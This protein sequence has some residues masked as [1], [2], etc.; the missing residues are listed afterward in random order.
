MGAPMAARLAD[1]GFDVTVFDVRR[2]VS[3]AFADGHKVKCSPSI[4]DAV[5]NADALVAML[6]DD[7]AVR[8]VMLGAGAA[9]CCMAAGGIAIDMGTSSPKSTL[10][11]AGI[12]ALNAIAYVDAPVM[13]GVRFAQDG[14]LDVMV[15]GDADAVERCLPLFAALGRNTWRCGASGSGHALKAIANF[16]NAATLITLAEGMAAG[17]KFGLDGQFLAQALTAM[18]A[19]RQHPLEKKVIPQIMTRQ[20]NSGMAM[21]LIAKDVGI[22]ADLARDIGARATIAQQTLA[23]WQEAVERYGTTADQ[24]AVARLWE[25]AAGVNIE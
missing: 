16:I 13:G 3:E 11:I 2:D 4:A 15:G 22:A 10:E 7:A 17:R 14:S 20:F 5:R 21:A 25:D 18:C 23:L 6:P 24:M 8:A 19:G 9:A 12:L 1:Q